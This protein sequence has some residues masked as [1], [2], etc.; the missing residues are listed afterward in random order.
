MPGIAR[1]G[2]QQ[3]PEISCG[4]L[5][6]Q[7]DLSKHLAIVANLVLARREMAVPE[8][9]KLFLQWTV[10]RD[11]AVRPPVRNAARLQHAGAQPEEEAIGDRLQASRSVGLG[12]NAHRR[13]CLLREARRGR[14]GR[15]KRRQRRIVDARMIERRQVTVV[16][17]LEVDERRDR[18][19]R[20]HCDQSRHVLRGTA[21]A[22][23]V[24]EMPGAL[25]RPVRCADR[26]EVLF[27]GVGHGVILPDII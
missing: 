6:E 25:G 20:R 12:V 23:A 10:R 21:E 4:M 15:R 19:L 16:D 11:H 13:A 18:L 2:R 7:R 27:P 26:R 14:A 8:Q 9:R 3:R 5:L 1:D 17:R 22:R 24:Q